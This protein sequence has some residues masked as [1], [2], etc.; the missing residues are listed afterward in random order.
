MK[1][2]RVWGEAI[3]TWVETGDLAKA[4]QTVERQS[5]T[6]PEWLGGALQKKFDA[7]G[8]K[9]EVYW[10]GSLIREQ[11]YT[12]DL[13]TGVTTKVPDKFSFLKLPGSVRFIADIERPNA[14]EDLKT[15][16]NVPGAD[17][18]QTAVGC[19][20]LRREASII[21]HWP[22]YKLKFL[23]SRGPNEGSGKG[24]V[25]YRKGHE[26]KDIKEE[27]TDLRERAKRSLQLYNAGKTPEVFPGEHC[28]MCKRKPG[29]PA[30]SF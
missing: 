14:I 3:H 2:A 28:G 13:D 18:L 10:S 17:S 12:Y 6:V 8:I 24:S 25:L 21:T 16:F 20:A 4:S 19:L 1:R 5:K 11:C 29:C 22:R 15:G 30:H 7:C 26:L 23:P 27:L 9:R